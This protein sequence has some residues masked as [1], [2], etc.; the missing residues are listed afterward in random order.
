MFLYE[1]KHIWRFS[2]LYYCTFKQTRLTVKV[3]KKMACLVDYISRNVYC[4]TEVSSIIRGRHVY[5]C[6]AKDY[7][8]LLLVYE[9][10]LWVM[11]Q[12]KYQVYVITFWTVMNKTPWL[13]LPLGNE[14]ERLVLLFQRNYFFKQKTENLLKYCEM[15]IYRKLPFYLAKYCVFQ[16]KENTKLTWCSE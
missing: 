5:M 12:L 7:V 13:L 9:I 8:K 10:C 16:Q 4:T 6:E 15:R 14:I 2:S 1:H 3:T 11:Y